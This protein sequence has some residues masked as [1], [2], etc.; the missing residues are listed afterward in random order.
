MSG[1]NNT[2]QNI[3]SEKKE[4]FNHLCHRHYVK[5]LYVFGSAVTNSFNDES[6]I[7]FLYSFDL[8]KFSDWVH[9]DYDY[10]DNLL[11]F[12]EE[13]S[14]FFNRKVD[15]VPDDIITNKYLKQNIEKTKYKVYAA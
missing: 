13:L 2:I 14:Q 9:A 1:L 4:K 11:R 10:A 3:I 8:E 5:S 6:D 15:L 7:D 12:E